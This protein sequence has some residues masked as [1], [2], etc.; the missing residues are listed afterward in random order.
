MNVTRLRLWERHP[1]D[2]SMPLGLS[3]DESGVHMG[4][5]VALIEAISDHQG[6]RSYRAR[7]VRLLEAMLSAGYG[8]A[9]DA[10]RLHERLTVIAGYLNDR[11]LALASIA[12]VQLGL[13]ELPDQD[14][15]QRMRDAAPLLKDWNPELHPR[16]GGPP[17]AGWFA[18]VDHEH[19]SN[20][21]ASASGG[22]VDATSPV[23]I[24]FSDGF[25]DAVVDVW[26][27]FFREKGIPV[28]KAP[29]IQVVGPNKSIIGFPDMFIHEPGYPVEAIEVKT[30]L[31]PTLT[32][33][34]AWYYPLLQLGGHIYSTDPRITAL[35]LQPGVPFP[36][37]P[38]YILYAPGP[39]LPYQMKR[40]PP[41]SFV[42]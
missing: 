26:V 1:R 38:V 4:G 34:Q 13:P 42:H 20:S 18:P 19:Q 17:N 6:R 7:S 30:G 37:M 36:P 2:G 28:L 35:G 11:K 40:L 12:T 41:P 3:C 14:A 31:N 39:N 24:D 5:S 25:H 33:N 22:A 16:A 29:A 32:P 8:I 9:V 23:E 15:V 21:T 27:A 10:H